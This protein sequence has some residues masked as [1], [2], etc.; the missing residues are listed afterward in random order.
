MHQS[1]GLSRELANVSVSSILLMMAVVNFN[2][3]LNLPKVVDSWHI[4]ADNI[5]SLLIYLALVLITGLFTWSFWRR[6]TI[7]KNLVVSIL[8]ALSFAL[9]VGAAIYDVVVR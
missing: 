5:L 9:L 1:A 4:S 8:N 2:A 3:T 7:G 6:R